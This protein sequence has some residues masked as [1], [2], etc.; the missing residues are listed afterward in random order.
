MGENLSGQS[1]R[2]KITE[3]NFLWQKTLTFFVGLY[4]V[5]P[6]V[7]DPF[8]GFLFGVWTLLFDGLSVKG[9]FHVSAI[10]PPEIQLLFL[11]KGPTL[12]TSR[13][14]DQK[15]NPLCYFK[16]KS[17]CHPNR[18]VTSN[19]NSP[20]ATAELRLN[21]STLYDILNLILTKKTF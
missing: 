16:V 10:S 9:R 15:M 19:I 4:S 6:F 21:V 3:A 18:C 2:A 12:M 1:S 14:F 17:H 11:L 13:K 5:L 20:Q 7:F 8:R